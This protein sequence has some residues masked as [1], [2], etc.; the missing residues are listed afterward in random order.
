MIHEAAVTAYTIPGSF[1]TALSALRAALV[2]GGLSISG[3]MDISERIRRQVGLDFGPCL[4]LMVDSPYVLVEALALD[5][6]A[7][8]LLPLHVVVSERDAVTHVSWISMAGMRQARLP[9]G[10][11]APLA[12]LHADLARALDGMA[13]REHQ[14]PVPGGYAS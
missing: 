4:I 9:A 6:S 11:E 2:A 14:W 13:R 8:A 10:A 5:R 1:D 3:E 12:K 7:A